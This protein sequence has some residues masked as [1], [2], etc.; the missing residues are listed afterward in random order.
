MTLRQLS[1]LI[2]LKRQKKEKPIKPNN[3][4]LMLVLEMRNKP[5]RAILEMHNTSLQAILEMN[6]RNALLWEVKDFLHKMLKQLK[7][8]WNHVSLSTHI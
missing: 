1:R 5:L 6:I 3:K 4:Q 2:R 7:K 8:L